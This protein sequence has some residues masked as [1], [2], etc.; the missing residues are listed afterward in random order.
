MKYRNLVYKSIASLGPENSAEVMQQYDD[1][2][3][4]FGEEKTIDILHEAFVL[5]DSRAS[6]NYA[7]MLRPAAK[8]IL[9]ELERANKTLPKIEENSVLRLRALIE[10]FHR[11]LEKCGAIIDGKEAVSKEELDA[12]KISVPQACQAKQQIYSA[13]AANNSVSKLKHLEVELR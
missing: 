10:R 13:F 12:I 11:N 6:T 4:Q 5:F 1:L 3:A 8:A 2:T 9:G 7:P